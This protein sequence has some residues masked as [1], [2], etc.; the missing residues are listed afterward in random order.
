MTS[1]EMLASDLDVMWNCTRPPLMPTDFRKKAI[2][3]WICYLEY[4]LSSCLCL[5]KW[6]LLMMVISNF[7]EYCG[8]NRNHWNSWNLSYISSYILKRSINLNCIDQI[9]FNHNNN[10]AFVNIRHSK[11]KMPLSLLVFQLLALYIYIYTN[12]RS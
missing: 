10:E 12:C 4:I 8:N 2:G 1:V 9:G 11:H 5:Q 7:L 6:N 3:L